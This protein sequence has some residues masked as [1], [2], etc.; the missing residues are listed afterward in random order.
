MKVPF[1]DLKPQFSFI[2]EEVKSAIDEVFKTQQFI[3]GPKVEA[4]EQVIAQLLPDSICHRCGF[5][6][7]CSPFVANGFGD[8]RR[9]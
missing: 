1:F 9:R 2:E 7:G 5:W 8:W 6:I 4:L 3:L